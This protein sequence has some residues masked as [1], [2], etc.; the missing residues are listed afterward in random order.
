MEQK[1][2]SFTETESFCVSL[3]GGYSKAFTE[4]DMQV[5]HFSKRKGGII[6]RSCEDKIF[7]SLV[8]NN[9]PPFE[10]TLVRVIIYS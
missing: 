9:R 1:Q 2:D 7:P 6:V 4:L 3:E 5:Y 10:G 8:D